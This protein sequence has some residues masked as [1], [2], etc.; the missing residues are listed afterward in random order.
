MDI[1]SRQECVGFAKMDFR[2]T[3]VTDLVGGL[4]FPEPLEVI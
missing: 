1:S 4:V 3:T 2:L